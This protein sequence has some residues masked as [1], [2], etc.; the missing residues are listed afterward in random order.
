[1]TRLASTRL[2]RPSSPPDPEDLEGD[3][4]QPGHGLFGTIWVNP[5]RL[6]GAPCFANTR[7]PVQNLF[8]YLAGGQPLS[9]FMEDFPGV[10]REQVDAVIALAARGL[11]EQLPCA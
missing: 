10:T 11:L 6:S 4:L 9:E 3:L 8:D 7:V 1:M 2:A 5:D